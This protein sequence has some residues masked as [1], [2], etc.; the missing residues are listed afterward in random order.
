[1]K[2]TLALLVLSAN[3]HSIP[4]GQESGFLGV[5]PQ[6]QSRRCASG[7]SGVAIANVHR[8]SP[9]EAA[10]L[11][12]GDIVLSLDGVGLRSIDDFRARIGAKRTGDCITLTVS[13]RIGSG[14]RSSIVPVVAYAVNR[15]AAFGGADSYPPYEPERS[16]YAQVP[17]PVPPLEPAVVPVPP[18]VVPT[19]KDPDVANTP[20]VVEPAPPTAPQLPALPPPLPTRLKLPAEL[21]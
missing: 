7:I 5:D 12:R 11:R 18:E 6:W 16:P 19:P 4:A 9:A 13:R 3:V 2:R 1:M 10:G 17:A 20:E 8:N 21:S 14:G 15:P